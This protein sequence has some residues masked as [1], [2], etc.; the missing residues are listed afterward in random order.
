MIIELNSVASVFDTKTLNVYPMFNDTAKDFYGIAYDDT[1]PV[2][3]SKCMNDWLADL[4]QEDISLIRIYY[5]N[6]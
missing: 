1:N 2:H 4:S 6:L 3:I 5:K